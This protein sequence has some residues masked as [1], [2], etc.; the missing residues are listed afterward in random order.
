MH[1]IIIFSVLLLILLFYRADSC[2]IQS[3]RNNATQNYDN[4]DFA[5][6]SELSSNN[7]TS[8]ILLMIEKVCEQIYLSGTKNINNQNLTIM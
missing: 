6:D 7:T 2:V 3:Y 5:I 4:L 1:K 8:K